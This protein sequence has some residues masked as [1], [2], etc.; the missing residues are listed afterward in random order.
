MADGLVKCEQ[1]E[2]RHTQG[3]GGALY[4]WC[5]RDNC[6]INVHETCKDCYIAELEQRIEDLEGE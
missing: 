2:V 4:W 1:R 5:L 3:C 6:Q